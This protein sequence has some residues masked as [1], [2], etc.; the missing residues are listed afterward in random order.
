MKKY[1]ILFPL[2]LCGLT[3]QAQDQNDIKTLSLQQAIDMA[4]QLQPAYK[5]YLLDKTL[6][7]EQTRQQKGKTFLPTVTGNIDLRNNLLL[8]PIALPG[9]IFGGPNATNDFVIVQ[10]G[11]RLNGTAG[12]TAT[13]PLVDAYNWAVLKTR[14]LNEEAT[15]TALDKATVDLQVNVTRAYY[16]ALL[17]QSQLTFAE[18]D[19]DRNE[20][21]HK[22]LQI[23]QQNERA[24]PT[25]VTRA[26]LNLSNAK[27]ALQSVRKT[28]ALAKSFLAVQL[29]L[30]ERALI[31]TTL[32]DNL[33][34]IV[35]KPDGSEWQAAPADLAA[36]RV[37]YRN[38][39]AQSRLNLNT[40]KEQRRRYFP[41]VNLVG[42]VAGLGYANDGTFLDFGRRWAGYSYVALQVAIPIF[43]GLDKNS[44]VRQN[45]MR[46]QRNRNTMASLAQ[47]F[48]YETSNARLQLNDALEALRIQQQNV[49]LAQENT[50]IT[51]VRFAE[52]RALAQET[53]DAETTLQQTQANYF[54]A[55]YNF[56]I[57]K[58][59]WQ[60]VTATVSSN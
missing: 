55:L 29:G 52:G 19:V 9:T 16:N 6:A 8:Q 35:G 42:Y 51:R 37:E 54:T 30:D 11:T 32:T 56:L 24:L 38:E 28:L 14:K 53:L 25:D 22:D 23:R 40:A 58:L 43:D 4:K 2:I 18:K 13:I 7:A 27:L 39:E 1:F 48:G 36:S 21:L 34:A 12:I 60:R 26:Y 33:D 50:R 47:N 46:A 31:N 57:A 59:E 5:N 20:L 44:Q 17:A 41:T 3:A 45:L 15:Q 10:Q 49:E